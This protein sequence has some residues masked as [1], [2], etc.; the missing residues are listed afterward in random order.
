MSDFSKSDGIP[1]KVFASVWFCT[2]IQKFL[3]GP[4]RPASLLFCCSENTEPSPHGALPNPVSSLPRK[5]IWPSKMS[6]LSAQCRAK[7]SIVAYVG[8]VLGRVAVIK[9]ALS[10]T[11]VL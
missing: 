8:C 2:L 4:L 7:E 10:S 1:V 9:S 6:S 11:R 5:A 3:C